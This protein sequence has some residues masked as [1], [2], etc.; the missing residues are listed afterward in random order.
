MSAELLTTVSEAVRAAGIRLLEQYSPQSRPS[1]GE[2]LMAA[3]RRNEDLV[4]DQLRPALLAA[5]PG[6]QWDQDEHG[7]GPMS[8]GDWWVVDPV[9]GNVNTVHGMIDWNVGVSL[10][11][12]GRP[13][14]AVL[15]AP[16][17]DELFTAVAGG[18]A[19]LNG[20]PLAVSA[21][22]DLTM[23]LAGTGQAKPS[24]EPAHARRV[25]A[26]ITA[27]LQ[28]ALYV[29]MSVPVTH[30]L[31]QVAAGRMDLHWQFDNVRSH[32]GPVL[33][34]QEA[35]GVVTHLD[36][37]PWR[38]DGGAYLAAAPGLH[39]AALDVLSEVK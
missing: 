10:V 15:Y 26:G 30:Q 17:A 35:G 3:I 24:R 28:A 14:L 25:G 13:E 23:A 5:L 31:P 32:I 1:T 2:E 4:T 16:L 8:A 33:I 20:R 39:A 9:G 36:G 21:K 29:R 18:G 7:T 19:R 11:R 34:V 37:S 12:D 27:M 6:S 38:I 22:T